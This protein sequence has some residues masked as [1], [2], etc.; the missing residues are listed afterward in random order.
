MYARPS[1]R[2]RRIKPIA[3]IGAVDVTVRYD[4]VGMQKQRASGCSDECFDVMEGELLFSRKESNFYRDNSLHVMSCLNGIKKKTKNAEGKEVDVDPGLEFAGVA[5]TGFSPRTDVYEQGF[6]TQI[7]G[8]CSVYNN[9]GDYIPAGATV[10]AKFVLDSGRSMNTNN[11]A[12]VPYRKRLVT[13]SKTGGQGSQPIGTCVK[14]GG[15]KAT[16]DIILHRCGADQLEFPPGGDNDGVGANP[17]VSPA[18]PPF[19]PS[20]SKKS[21]SSK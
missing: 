10:Y 20:R 19:K 11:P 12:G 14:G 9:S 2:Q 15:S 7:S 8:L 16:I 1:K 13:L 4:L 18:N 5:V 6:V 21:K 17:L 3:R